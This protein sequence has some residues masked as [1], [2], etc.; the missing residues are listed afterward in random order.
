[1]HI[2]RQGADR[3]EWYYINYAYI[4][5][6]ESP[7]FRIIGLNPYRLILWIPR[8]RDSL[9][10]LRLLPRFDAID[11][12][13]CS[14][15]TFRLDITPKYVVSSKYEFSIWWTMPCSKSRC[16][17]FIASV[18]RVCFQGLSLHKCSYQPC[19]PVRF[20][21]NNVFLMC[22]GRLSWEGEGRGWILFHFL[23][24]SM[25]LVELIS[26][27]F[28]YTSKTCYESFLSTCMCLGKR[29]I[30]HNL[31]Q[32]GILHLVNTFSCALWS[33]TVAIFIVWLPRANHHARKTC[34]EILYRKTTP[35]NTLDRI[36]AVWIG[37]VPRIFVY[38]KRPPVEACNPESMLWA[39]QYFESETRETS[40]I[41]P[42][43]ELEIFE[44]LEIH[45][46]S[47]RITYAPCC[48][49]RWR[50]NP[51]VEID[52]PSLSA[53]DN[54]ENLICS[55]CACPP[56]LEEYV[57]AANQNQFC[58][59]WSLRAQCLDGNYLNNLSRCLQ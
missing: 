28:L 41:H 21:V 59:V 35:N 45:A 55:R 8:H 53:S 30:L 10:L 12:G 18:G 19:G 43:W 47:L 44:I 4:I 42:D 38:G 1:M 52:G 2:C 49:V 36:A 56:K 57:G 26:W 27:K 3:S 24:T 7:K 54:T 5:Y 33:R 34:I 46:R 32:Y 20:W 37:D 25:N 15:T 31:L 58:R 6:T 40:E 23:W 14:E 16:S 13:T 17:W 51:N 11:S 48:G 22:N 39:S 9:L 50:R 29:M